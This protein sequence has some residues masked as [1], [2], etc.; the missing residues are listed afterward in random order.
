MNEEKDNKYK[1]PYCG[2]EKVSP[3]II[4][5]CEVSRTTG[6]LDDCDYFSR[7]NESRE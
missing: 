6:Y 5:K 1:C 2:K 3:A 4:C 7:D